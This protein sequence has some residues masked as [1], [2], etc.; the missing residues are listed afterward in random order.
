MKTLCSRFDAL[1]ATADGVAGSPNYAIRVTNIA[2]AREVFYW[3]G[4]GERWVREFALDLAN[5]IYG[6]PT[7]PHFMP[8]RRLYAV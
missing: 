7:S 6:T 8:G 2:T 5:G 1:L 4:L 3:G